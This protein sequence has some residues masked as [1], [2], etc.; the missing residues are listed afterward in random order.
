MKA[1]AAVLCQ[2]CTEKIGLHTFLFRR[3]V[4]GIASP[5]C[6]C[7]KGD[8]TVAHLFAECMDPKSRIMQTMNFSTPGA[9][10]KNLSD[11]KKALEMARALISSCWLPQ[12]RV[13]N[14]LRLEEFIEAEATTTA[15]EEEESAWAR[16]LPPGQA[17]RQGRR[18][19]PAL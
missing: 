11:Y 15:G 10:M 16:C 19:N 14:K 2:A 6:S 13:Y 17:R 9:V 8:Q 1:E 5:T 18:R 3:G 7:G 12:F 4:P